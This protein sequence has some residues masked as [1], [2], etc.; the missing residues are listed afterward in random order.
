MLPFDLD[1]RETRRQCA[2]R[3]DMLWANRVH[4]GVEI[5]KIATSH[6]DGA[7]TQTDCACI[8]TIEVDKSF[9]CVFQLASVIKARGIRGS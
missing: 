5:D 2:A 3:H 6:V 7:D 4:L 9:E 1:R 8:E